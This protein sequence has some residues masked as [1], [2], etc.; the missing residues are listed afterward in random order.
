MTDKDWRNHQLNKIFDIELDLDSKGGEVKL[1]NSSIYV[2]EKSKAIG[3]LYDGEIE[4]ETRLSRATHIINEIV[5][6]NDNVSAVVTILDT[7]LGKEV[8]EE[9]KTKKAKLIAIEMKQRVF[10]LDIELYD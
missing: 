8:K 3:C 1:E 6:E 2:L 5:I 7:H 9:I 10:R 4:H